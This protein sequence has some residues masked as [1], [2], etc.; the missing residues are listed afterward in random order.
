ML[1]KFKL[2]IWKWIISSQ[3]SFFYKINQTKFFI[4]NILKMDAYINKNL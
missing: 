3:C 2:K 1:I 4:Y